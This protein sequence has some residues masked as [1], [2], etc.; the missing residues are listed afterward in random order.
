MKE[1]S[2]GW[3]S[4]WGDVLIDM[5]S[6]LKAQLLTSLKADLRQDLFSTTRP[7]KQRVHLHSLVWRLCIF[8]CVLFYFFTFLEYAISQFFLCHFYRK[9]WKLC[10]NTKTSWHEFIDFFPS[11]KY[12]VMHFVN[13]WVRRTKSL[14]SARGQETEDQKEHQEKS[15]RHFIIFLGPS[16]FS[17]RSIQVSPP[18]LLAVL[19]PLSKAFG[20]FPSFPQGNPNIYTYLKWS[21]QYVCQHFN[22][23]FL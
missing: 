5:Y 9:K 19:K 20:I 23:R 11:M 1:C 21:C 13:K 12:E 8:D 10:W 7:K 3:S 14:L 15:T 4:L 16:G 2:Q 17:W 18:P 22:K 6:R